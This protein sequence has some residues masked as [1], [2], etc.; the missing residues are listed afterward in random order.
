MTKRIQRKYKLLRFY[1]EDLWGRLSVSA[2]FKKVKINKLLKEIRLEKTF[3]KRE[4]EAETV[5]LKRKFG[6]LDLATMRALSGKAKVV[7]WKNYRQYK[8]LLFDFIQDLR[9]NR[10]RPVFNFRTDIGKPKRK[11]RRL[12]TF[13]RRMKVRQKLRRFVTGSMGV[14]QFRSYLKRARKHVSLIL[15]FF[16]LFETRLDSLVFRLN[17]ATSAGEARQLINHGNFLV[18]ANRV[19]FASHTIEMYDVVTVF[20]KKKFVAKILNLFKQKMVISSVPY[21]LEVNFRILA[22]TLFM[23]P[24]PNKVFYPSPE[25]MDAGLLASSGSKFSH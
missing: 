6:V 21:Y 22:A 7:A 2:S 5:R 14:R 4:I 8:A 18:N 24:F 3:F 15:F 10:L 13:G 1:Q 23:S 19:I 20:D 25:K 16:R 12:T 17:F 11:V 9:V